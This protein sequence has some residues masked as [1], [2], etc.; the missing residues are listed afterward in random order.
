[1]ARPCSI[2]SHKAR[3]AIDLA[4]VSRLN[5]AVIAERYGVSFHSLKR[6]YARHLSP[7]QRLALASAVTPQGVG[8]VSLDELKRVEGEH[9]LANLVSQR[10]RLGNYAELAA[11]TGNIGEANNSERL[12]QRNLELVARLIGDLVDR[13]EIRHVSLFTSADYYALRSTLS[14]ALRKHP[15]AARDVAIA[16][17][18]MEGVMLRSEPTAPAP[19]EPKL[20]EHTP[21][22]APPT[23]PVPR[24]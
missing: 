5:Q 14:E 18:K 13:K 15:A 7:A 21:W 12:I 16:L 6:H 24:C 19:P 17:S 11:A 22:P 23:P 3:A 10:C 20:I 1:M 4:L 9:L 2:C 8:G